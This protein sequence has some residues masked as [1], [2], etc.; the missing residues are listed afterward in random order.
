MRIHQFGKDWEYT[1][2]CTVMKVLDQDVLPKPF[3]VKE[4]TEYISLFDISV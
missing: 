4:V 3:T 1:P 2:C